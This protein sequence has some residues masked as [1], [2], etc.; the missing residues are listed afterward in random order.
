MYFIS[1]F[2][3]ASHLLPQSESNELVSAYLQEVFNVLLS[4]MTVKRPVSE[5]RKQNKTNLEKENF[6]DLLFLHL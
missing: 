5:R 2:K 1:I 3:I 6:S 4:E